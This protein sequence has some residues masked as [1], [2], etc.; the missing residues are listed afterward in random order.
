K[1]RD[2]LE[3]RRPLVDDHVVDVLERRQVHGAQVLRD[4]RAVVP[5]HDVRVRCEARYENVR[6][7]LRVREVAHVT[8]MHEVERAVA[9]HHLPIARPWAE[10]LLEFL[11][12][13]DLPTVPL[14]GAH[15]V[16]SPSM[17][18][19]VSVAFAMEAVSQT[20][21]VRQWSMWSTISATPSSNDTVGSQ[22]SSVRIFVVSAH[23]TS[24]SP[25]RLGTWITSPLRSSTSLLTDCGCP[26]P[27]L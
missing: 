23:V 26:A 13:L 27:R 6:F 25:G 22:P 18:N 16:F 3:G 1:Q 4:E 20:G 7:R 11:H 9:H 5:F 15:A 14:F 10:D 19:H 2:V 21:A 8:G 17:S 12:R 24:G